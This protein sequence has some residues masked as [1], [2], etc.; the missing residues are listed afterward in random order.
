M[1]ANPMRTDAEAMADKKYLPQLRWLI[2]GLLFF[3][4]TINYI[5][6]Q[7]LG[8]LK[9]VLEKDLGW[10][11]ADYGWIVSAFQIAYGLMMPIAG[12]VIDWLGVKLGYT[13]AVIVWSV[14]AMGHAMAGNAFQFSAARFSLGIGESANFPAAIKAVAHWFPKRERAFA[15]GI[16]NSGTNIG[17]LVAPWMVPILAT[18][19]GWRSAFVVTGS[20][21]FLWI[22]LWVIFFNEPE[23]HKLLSPAE[24]ELIRSDNEPNA[25]SLPYSQVL[26]SRAAWAFIVG[27]F[28]TDPIWWFYL[29]WLP[30]FLA[31]TYK[32][33]LSHLGLPIIVVYFATTVGSVFGGWLSSTMIRRGYTVNRARKTAM[34]TCALAVTSAMFVGQAGGNLWL[35]VTLISI[36]AASHQGWSANLFTLPSDMLPKNAVGSVV[37]LGGMFGA[38]SGALVAPAIGYWLDYSNKS[39]GPLF[40]VAGSMYLIALGIIHLI[41]PKIEQ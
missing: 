21:G 40:I 5:D 12:R 2:C 9:P 37:G 39:Y 18:H 4:S 24:L 7:V 11:E 35:A 8:L 14:A 3:A 28:F 1:Q 36:A 33:D 41:V 31:S 19:Y 23:R 34:L 20:L 29:F 13:L 15:T 38:L 25:A 17:A 27:K 16:F 32:L 26:G 10:N 6:R 30:G 22:I